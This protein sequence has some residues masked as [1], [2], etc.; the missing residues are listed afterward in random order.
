MTVSVYRVADV[1]SCGS[2]DSPMKAD[3]D[4]LLLI[5]LAVG[6]AVLTLVAHRPDA[7]DTTYLGFSLTFL[8]D[9]AVPLNRIVEIHNANALVAYHAIV[10]LAAAVSGIPIL[11]IYYLI[12]PAQFFFI[13]VCL[14]SAVS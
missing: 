2:V 8:H 13:A 4:L 11:Y 1:H 9:P 3:D 12:M 14:L 5:A 6:A 7:D 10:A